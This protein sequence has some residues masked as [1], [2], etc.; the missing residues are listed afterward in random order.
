MGKF[1]VSAGVGLVSG[2][3][4]FF[5]SVAFLS[6]LLLGVN[7]F[8]DKIV[9]M[10]IVEIKLEKKNAA[11]D[12]ERNDLQLQFNNWHE[13]STSL[14]GGSVVL[15]LIGAGWVGLTGEKTARKGGKKE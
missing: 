5:L 8:Q 11:N 3:I 4:C 15:A 10:K 9:R 6:L 1:F 13:V 2:V 14:F 12:G 7:C